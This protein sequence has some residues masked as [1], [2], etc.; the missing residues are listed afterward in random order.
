M[1]ASGRLGYVDWARGACVRGLGGP[2]VY[3]RGVT[4]IVLAAA[5]LASALPGWSP[6]RN[7][8]GPASSRAGALPL[9]SA[10]AGVAVLTAAMLALSLA[11]TELPGLTAGAAARGLR[12]AAR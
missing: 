4:L 6:L 8:G 5:A 11:R 7:W 2:A 3:P 10:A 1:A 9:A 12:R